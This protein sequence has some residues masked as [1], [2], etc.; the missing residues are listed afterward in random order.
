[1]LEADEILQLLTFRLDGQ[2]YAVEIAK[3]NEVMEYAPLTKIP[4]TPDYM[5]GLLNLRGSV[6][7]VIDLKTEFGMGAVE[8]TIDTSIIILDLQYEDKLHRIGALVD[9]VQAVID[10]ATDNIVDTPEMGFLV[11]QKLIKHVVNVNDEH[12]V[13]LDVDTA[14]SVAELQQITQVENALANPS[15]EAPAVSIAS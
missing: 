3:V 4:R 15:T 5:C 2:T 13:I 6:V 11:N 7:P 9:E 10:V 12:V 14:L 1:M 8:Q